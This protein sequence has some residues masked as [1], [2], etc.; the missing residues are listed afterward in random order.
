MTTQGTFQMN[1]TFR[2]IITS[3]LETDLYKFT[4]WQALLH[5]YPTTSAEYRFVCRNTPAAPL[6]EL[7]DE[8][9]EQLDHL[10]SLRFAPDELDYLAGLRYIKPDF[11]QFLRVFQLHRPFIS[12][13]AE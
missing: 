9:N 1:K 4:M 2:P 12:A 11:V 7:V 8:V 10:C 13:R 6:A 3:L 5:K